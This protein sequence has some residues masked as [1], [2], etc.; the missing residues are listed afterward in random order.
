MVEGVWSEGSELGP[1][2]I[3]ERVCVCTKVEEARVQLRGG[4]REEEQ[5]PHSFLPS[6]RLA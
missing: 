6:I 1:Q 5:Y 4:G 2:L 3:A